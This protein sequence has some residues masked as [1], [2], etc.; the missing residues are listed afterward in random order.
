MK[1]STSRVEV[2]SLLLSLSCQREF[3][4][5]RRGP[6]TQQAPL[7][8]LTRAG[9]ECAPL[10]SSLALP[11]SF[12]SPLLQSSLDPVAAPTSTTLHH[13]CRL[14][15]V[16]TVALAAARFC[17]LTTVSFP[18]PALSLFSSHLTHTLFCS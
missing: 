6:S 1:R 3:S 15:S 17:S 8:R 11:F 5:P 18:S 9:R 4:G 13:S 14:G 12:D 7:E 16:T 2:G 10:S